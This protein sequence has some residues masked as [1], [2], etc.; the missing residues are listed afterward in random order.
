MTVLKKKSKN[1]SYFSNEFIIANH[2]DI[3][4]VIAM[5]FIGGMLFQGPAK[6]AS[7]FVS[8][9]HNASSDKEVES[10]SDVQYTVGRYDI[11]A[12]FFYTL[13]CI[14]IHA[15]I[16]EYLLDKLSKKLHLPR[17]MQSKFNESGQLLFFYV[18]SVYWAVYAIINERFLASLSDLW[19]GYPHSI[20][21]FWIKVFFVFQ[22]SYW[23]HNFPE[24]YFQKVKKSEIPSRIYYSSL[25]LIG[26]I[27][28]YFMNFSKLTMIMLVLH[29]TT[30][31]FF[32]FARLM[33]FYGYTAVVQTSFTIYD[34]LYVISRS[35][36]CV[37][38]F[39]TFYYGL[40]QY[41]VPT[42]N[43]S[44]GNYNTWLIRLNCMLFVFLT[45]AYMIWTF[46]NYHFAKMRERKSQMYTN[47]LY[48]P[49]NDVQKRKEKSQ[50]KS[51]QEDAKESPIHGNNGVK[52][53]KQKAQ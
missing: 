39:L 25:F 8:M 12:F 35:L 14:I 17:F 40:P 1:P 50:K 30:D 51:K 2:G 7:L 47:N 13:I 22:I 26:L 23:I 21:P 6:V 10:I 5:V 37:L 36:C 29:Y 33:K 11:L 46:V 27:A 43:L 15:I 31:F 45:Q 19:T 48:V 4:S 49:N 44:I 42:M 16:Q 24:L 41:S 53:K 3:V 34:G 32:H 20:L 38:A 9:Q 52:H 18:F 28:G